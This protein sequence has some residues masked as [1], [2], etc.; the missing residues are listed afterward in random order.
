MKPLILTLI[1]AAMPSPMAESVNT[2]LQKN[3]GRPYVWGATG[4]KS[5]DCSGVVWRMLS[6]HGVF[7][8]R[9]TA[10]KL[11][12]SLQKLEPEEKPNYGT[13]I[14]FNDLKHVG[15]VID[16]ERFFHAQS[17]RGTNISQLSPYWKKMIVGYRRLPMP[18]E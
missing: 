18:I 16:S 6:D 3:M 17:S 1:L 8:K 14:F 7:L 5:Y 9:T 4:Y 15:M 12:V 13:L 11:Y 2:W 10:R